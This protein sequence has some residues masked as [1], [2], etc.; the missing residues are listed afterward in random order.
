MSFRNLLFCILFLCGLHYVWP[1]RLPEISTNKSGSQNN[2]KLEVVNLNNDG[3]YK[4]GIIFPIDLP[5]VCFAVEVE[6]D[7][8]ADRITVST[9]TSGLNNYRY[10]FSGATGNRKH[11]P[12]NMYKKWNP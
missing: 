12:L 11:L 6:L 8:L 5:G 4:R 3:K 1:F 10:S 9:Q 7:M 2:L